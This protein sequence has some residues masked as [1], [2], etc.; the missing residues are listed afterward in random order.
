MGTFGIAMKRDSHKK[1]IE[2]TAER[3]P[4]PLLVPAKIIARDLSC[5]P[6]FVHMLAEQGK[7]PS[8]RFGRACIRFS[9]AAVLAALGIPTEA[10]GRAGE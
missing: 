9:R 10:A 4:A 5:T 8:H 7:I 1:Q 2:Q 6:R 3:I